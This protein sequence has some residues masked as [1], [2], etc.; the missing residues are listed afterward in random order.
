MGPARYYAYRSSIS[1]AYYSS[2]KDILRMG[3]WEE[4]REE[5]EGKE[6]NLGP[7]RGS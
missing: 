3:P 4:K 2:E 6:T 7:K 5:K 1:T